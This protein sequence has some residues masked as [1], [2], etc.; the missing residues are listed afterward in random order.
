MVAMVVDELAEEMRLDPT[1]LLSC[2]ITSRTGRLLYDESSKLWW[3]GPSD[4]A[5]MYKAEW[6][7]AEVRCG[8]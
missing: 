3:S 2:F 6:K 7:N 1:D 5:E 8:L 4:I